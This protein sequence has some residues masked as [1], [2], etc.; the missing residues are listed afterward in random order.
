MKPERA[1]IAERAAAQHCA[2][3]LNRGPAASD[4]LPLLGQAGQRLARLLPGA[5]AEL[6]GGEAPSV[7]ATP[8]REAS[9]ADLLRDLDELAANSLLAAGAQDTP[10]LASLD[11][12]AVLRLVDRAFGGKGE[13]PV[14]LPEAFPMSAQLMI[15]RLEALVA[16]QLAAALGSN[17]PAA[18][19][20]LRRDGKLADLAPFPA[21]AALAVLKL[22]VMEGMRVP[23]RITLA[24][25]L[26][27]LAVLLGHDG[28]APVVR[29][30]N[31]GPADPA[32]APFADLPLPLRAVLV[33][34]AVPLAAISKL[35]PGVVLPVAVARAVP[36]HIGT[37]LIARG[38]V[39]AQDDRVAV[40]LTQLA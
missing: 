30:A 24:L 19:R 10:L 11:G 22:E 18:V 37:T 13:A 17:D 4:L 31:S 9:M 40:K 8:P 28:R 15:Q 38:T 23:W 2:E 20:A 25:P 27:A 29:A 5:L 3:L 21:D 36:L 39:G 34:M 35:E 6:C 33:D 1:L 32:A 14:L 7:T 12:Y 16:A 26:G